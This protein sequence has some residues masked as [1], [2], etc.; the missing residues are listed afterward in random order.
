MCPS[1]PSFATRVFCIVSSLLDLFLVPL[2]VILAK[3]SISG[4]QANGTLRY[5]ASSNRTDL[6]SKDESF[7]QI[8]DMNLRKNTKLFFLKSEPQISSK[9]SLRL[10]LPAL[11]SGQGSQEEKSGVP[12]QGDLG[13]STK[14]RK[15]KP[16][17][18]KGIHFFCLDLLRFSLNPWV[19]NKSYLINFGLLSVDPLLYWRIILGT[20][21]AREHHAH[22]NIYALMISFNIIEHS[23]KGRIL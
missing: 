8:A 5:I 11:P 21:H 20:P 6:S 17:R 18:N 22:I 2:R 10:G 12:R 19:R 7:F 4:S 9:F 16:A 15:E 23:E 14:L 3:S 1:G 13:V